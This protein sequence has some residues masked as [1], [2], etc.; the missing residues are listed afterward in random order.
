MSLSLPGPLAGARMKLMTPRLL[1]PALLTAALLACGDTNEPTPDPGSLPQQLPELDGPR[2]VVL[3]SLDTLRPERLGLYGNTG[4]ELEVSPR[5][6]ALAHEAV[7]FDQCLAA[8]PWT[9]PSHMTMLTGLDPIAHGVKNAEHKLSDAA[10]TLAASLKADG[11]VTGGFTDG[12]YVIAQYGFDKGFDVFDDQ[13]SADGVNGF[14]RLLPPALKWLKARQAEEDVF[15]FLHTFDVHAPFQNGDQEV[16]ERFRTRPTPD[17]PDDWGLNIVSHM[18][19]Q[20]KMGLGGYA[21]LSELLNDYDAGV[22]EAD[23]GVGEVLDTLDEMGRLEDALVIVT[24]DHGESFFDQKLHIGHGIGLTDDELRV[25][26]IV[27]YPQRTAGGT[28][29]DELVGLVDIP[30]TVHEVMGVKA[31]EELQGESLAGL[32]QGKKRKVDYVLGASQ[33]TRSW[34][35]VQNGYKYITPVGMEPLHIAERHLGIQSP[36]NHRNPAGDS[37]YWLGGKEGDP[38]AV[39]LTY[40]KLGDPLGLNDVLPSAEQ[41]YD[42]RADPAEQNDLARVDQQ[43]T[44][45]GKMRGLFESHHAASEE[46]NAE[47]FPTEDVPERDAAD[48]RVLAALGYLD[49]PSKDKLRTISRHMRSWVLDPWVAPDTAQLVEADRLVQQVRAHMRDGEKPKLSDKEALEKAGALYVE[50]FKDHPHFQRRVVWRVLDVLELAAEDG[51]TLD[52]RKWADDIPPKMFGQLT[53]S[54][55]GGEADGGDDPR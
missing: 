9:L 28:R 15:L 29:R 11:F 18:F 54:P 23:R 13:R 42:R 50:W 21:R 38:G 48:T 33:N 43:G 44:I 27:R 51:F 16:I 10:P 55:A 7:V 37:T 36:P 34:F 30:R 5:L 41:L 46:L 52:T 40:D 49:A 2:T 20:T 17:H 22:F 24:S 47:F 8:S 31:P 12:G 39:E 25:P 53:G 19:Q 3:I 45:L 26:L 32:I 4:G 6:D 14:A 1:Y 35:L